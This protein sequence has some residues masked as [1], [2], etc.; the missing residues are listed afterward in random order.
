VNQDENT[1][2]PPPGPLAAYDIPRQK[3][4]AFAMVVGVSMGLA[5]TLLKVDFI[6]LADWTAFHAGGGMWAKARP[7]AKLIGALAAAVVLTAIVHEGVHGL[8]AVLFGSRPKFGVKI[9]LVYVT[10]DHRVPREAFIAIALAPLLILSPAFGLLAYSKI[11]GPFNL[12]AIF[13]LMVNTIGAV[14]DVWMTLKLLP[15]ARGAMVQDTKTGLEIWPPD[16][17]GAA[18]ADKP[19]TSG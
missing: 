6:P 18:P 14:G 16:A 5:C 9:P 4:T 13:C 15:Q 11:L 19:E 1:T 12:I 17:G 7:F 2:T 3:A 10:F 8:T